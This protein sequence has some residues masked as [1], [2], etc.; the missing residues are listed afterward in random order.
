MPPTVFGGGREGS[1]E[2]ANR[3]ATDAVETIVIGQIS[4][5]RCVDNAARDA[6]FHHKVAKTRRRSIEPLQI[7]FHCAGRAVQR[8]SSALR[9]GKNAYKVPRVVTKG[10][11]KPLSSIPPRRR[12]ARASSDNEFGSSGAGMGM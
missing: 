11:L 7:V 8:L 9:L 6:T 10:S 2:R 5:G 1:S 4:D 12:S 3:T